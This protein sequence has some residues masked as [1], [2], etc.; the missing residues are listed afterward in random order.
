MPSPYVAADEAIPRLDET[1]EEYMWQFFPGWVVSQRV[2]DATSW[3]WNFGYDI[4]RGEQRKWVCKLCVARKRGIPKALQHTGLQNAMKHLHTEHH[5]N[6][7]RGKPKS[8]AEKQRLAS[9]Q[10]FPSIAT[11]LKLDAVDPAQQKVANQI[12]KM[13]DR[14]KF[15]QLVTEWMVARSIPL[16]VTEHPELRAVFEYLNPQV[17]LQE[18]N[19]TRKAIRT[20]IIDAYSRHKDTVKLALRGAPGM[21]HYSFDGWRSGNR[22]NVFGLVCFYRNEV[23]DTPNKVVLGLPE[24]TETHTGENIAE[25]ITDLIEDFEVSDKTGFFVLD[26]ASSNDTAMDFIGQKLGFD[27]RS[28]RGRC[29]GHILNL[30]AKLLLFGNK[31]KPIE[32]FIETDERLTDAQYNLWRAYGPVGKIRILG[33]LIDSSNTLTDMLDKIQAAHIATGETPRERSR[34]PLRVIKDNQTRWLGSLYMIRRAIRLRSHLDALKVKFQRQWEDESRGRNGV[35]RASATLPAFLDEANWLTDTDWVAIGHI[36]RLLTIYEDVLKDLEGD[37][38][39]RRRKH[40][41]EGSYGNIWDVFPSYEY[42]LA[43]LEQY[44]D[45]ADSIPDPVQFKAGVNAA[46]ELINKYYTKLDEVYF[47]YAAY[48]FHPANRWEAMEKLWESHPASWLTKAK[49]I[50][51]Q[52]KPR[53]LLCHTV[54]IVGSRERTPRIREWLWT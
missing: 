52:V 23:D 24:I 39:V 31:E 34:Q 14:H 32:T 47:Y 4:Q 54:T 2:R 36:E 10:P 18:A 11:F 45:L 41:F 43:Q 44:K 22:K 30:S 26:N 7:P 6:A 25:I 13:F 29:F 8:R 12:I 3:A 38:Q 5:I 35:V 51:S 42:L 20:K 17:R 46:W 19:L 15:Q 40:G 1:Y 27:G 28:R 33:L 21:L 16:S 50:P 53:N 37:G 49:K 48:I 9:H